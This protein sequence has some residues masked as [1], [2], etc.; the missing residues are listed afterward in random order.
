MGGFQPQ[1]PTGQIAQETKMA[2][3]VG[4]RLPAAQEPLWH[5]FITQEAG[6][7]ISGK[8]TTQ[9][10]HKDTLDGLKRRLRGLPIPYFLLE[11]G[12]TRLRI[13]SQL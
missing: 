12:K 10:L 11:G 2:L 8:G 1:R 4:F 6:L 7:F 9:D 13:V 3:E 5:T